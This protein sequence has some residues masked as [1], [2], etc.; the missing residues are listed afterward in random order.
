MAKERRVKRRAG[1][2]A[3]SPYPAARTTPPPGDP[4]GAPTSARPQG[5]RAPGPVRAAGSAKPPAAGAGIPSFIVWTVG[6]IVIGAIVIVIAISQPTN[7]PPEP[8]GTPGAA[9]TTATTTLITPTVLTPPAIPSSGRTL[10]AA[11][12]PVVVDLYGDFRCS[13]C[14]NFTFGGTEQRLVDTYVA[15]GKARITWHDFLVIDKIKRETASRAAANAAWC[16]ADQGRF[17]PMHDW[18]YANQSPTEAASAFTKARLVAIA[19]RAGLDMSAFTPCLDAGTHNAD[20]AAEDAATP[21]EVGGT[22]TIFVNGA[23]VGDPQSVP[24]FAQIGA[25]IDAASSSPAPSS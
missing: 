25:A 11:S 17:W 24:S 5:P 10:G 4:D 1:T 21:P 14:Y 9:G 15:T 3:S 12:A 19:T 8:T 16:A 2:P 22:P 18:L 13:A 20:I 6:A 23:M 7:P